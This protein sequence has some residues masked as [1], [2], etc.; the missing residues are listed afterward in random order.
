MVTA[1][2]HTTTTAAI[3][4]L[5]GQKLTKTVDLSSTIVNIGT[6]ND[7]F[8]WTS[9]FDNILQESWPVEEPKA[10]GRSICNDFIVH[11]CYQSR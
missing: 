6:N 11:Q 7:L 5:I 9:N 1:S 4:D 2:L 3:G 10:G 8:T